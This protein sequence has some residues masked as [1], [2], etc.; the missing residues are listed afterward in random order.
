MGTRL[1]QQDTRVIK[2]A[3][4]K[5]PNMMWS[6]SYWGIDKN[7]DISADGFPPDF[8]SKEHAINAPL[9]KFLAADVRYIKEALGD[10]SLPKETETMKKIKTQ[11]A[12]SINAKLWQK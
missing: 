10:L 8:I 3:S 5:T 1:H 6:G 2:E 12:K 9:F 4:L 7:R 11:T